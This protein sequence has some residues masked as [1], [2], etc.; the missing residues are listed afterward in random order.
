MFRRTWN[1]VSVGFW[2]VFEGDGSGY[3]GRRRFRRGDERHSGGR[4]SSCEIKNLSY[5]F[6]FRR[7]EA[8]WTF[9]SLFTAV[10]RGLS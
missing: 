3:W 10:T 4:K 8:T 7:V 9:V 1:W 2:V 6:P 5:S